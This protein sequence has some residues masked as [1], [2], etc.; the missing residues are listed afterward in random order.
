[1]EMCY[2]GNLVMPSNYVV[3]NADEMEYVEGGFSWSTLG[4]S[5]KNLINKYSFAKC[6]LMGSG[7]T[8]VTIAKIAAGSATY[9]YAT[10]AT[11]LG[12]IACANWVVGLVIGVS[13][14]TA[15]YVMG[16][17]ECFR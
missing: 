1:M 7:I 4:K 11:T 15:I 13:A 14:V 12:S 9:L 3:V 6:A 5:L 2:N 8:M 16:T 10:I 17:W